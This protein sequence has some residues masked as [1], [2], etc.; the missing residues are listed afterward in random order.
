MH[1]HYL[2]P[3]IC[4][5]NLSEWKL[6]LKT[7]WKICIDN[8][9][10]WLITSVHSN[11]VI[12]GLSA[13]AY[14]VLCSVQSTSTLY[15]IISLIIYTHQYCN[16]GI[17]NSV[18]QKVDYPDKYIN[19]CVLFFSAVVGWRQEG[20]IETSHS[21]RHSRKPQTDGSWL[22]PERECR[23]NRTLQDLWQIQLPHFK[24]GKILEFSVFGTRRI[25]DNWS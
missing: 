2:I 24:A 14:W 13:W 6:I 9:T 1:P 20:I 19:E 17:G 25:V 10:R 15:P 21:T 22:D 5:S 7:L 8:I 16:L 12:L 4:V 18:S 11:Y 3:H 23:T